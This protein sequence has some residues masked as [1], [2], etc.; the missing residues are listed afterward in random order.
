MAT[1]ARRLAP[2]L[3]WNAIAG[4]YGRLADQLVLAT[5]VQA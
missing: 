1:E 4:R 3:S 2:E 5:P